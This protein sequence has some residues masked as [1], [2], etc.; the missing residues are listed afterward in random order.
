ML[1]KAEM[2]QDGT[3]TRRALASRCAKQCRCR[4]GVKEAAMRAVAVVPVT[5]QAAQAVLVS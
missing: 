1:R 5:V 4:E 2:L 3:P